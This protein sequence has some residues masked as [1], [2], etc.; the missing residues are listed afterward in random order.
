MTAQDH[1]VFLVNAGL[2][3]NKAS[4]DKLESKASEEHL[5]FRER[6]VLSVCSIDF[7][8][9]DVFEYQLLQFFSVKVDLS[10]DMNFE[11]EGCSTKA[12]NS[13][14]VAHGLCCNN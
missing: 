9:C 11:L 7:I 6:P 12:H 3:A 2:L 1:A 8:L 4:L 10:F 13:C 5:D 14:R